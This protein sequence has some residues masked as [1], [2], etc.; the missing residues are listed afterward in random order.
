MNFRTAK[1]TDMFLIQWTLSVEAENASI[2]HFIE[3]LDNIR[4]FWKGKNKNMWRLNK[5]FPISN[6]QK[7]SKDNKKLSEITRFEMKIEI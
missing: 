7:H 6:N 1:V 3:M 4:H 2:G 5:I